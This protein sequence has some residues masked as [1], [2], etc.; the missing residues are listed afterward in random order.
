MSIALLRMCECVLFS[1]LNFEWTRPFASRPLYSSFVFV[2]YLFCSLWIVTI[3]S[4]NKR[5]TPF[6][7]LS[8]FSLDPF[9]CIQSFLRNCKPLTSLVCLCLFVFLNHQWQD[10]FHIYYVL[11]GVSNY[12]LFPNIRIKEN[13]I[14]V[15]FVNWITNRRKCRKTTCLFHTYT[16]S[17][18]LHCWVCSVW[19]LPHSF[20][21]HSSPLSFLH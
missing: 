9:H 6:P 2:R 21:F 8:P 4:R 20:L 12:H 3:W 10:P 19:T 17:I 14:I 5:V 16:T 15:S 18:D 11:S 1:F 13:S 7:L